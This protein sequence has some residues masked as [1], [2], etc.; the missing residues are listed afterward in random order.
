MRILHV[1]DHSVPAAQRLYLPHP[2]HPARAAAPGL[3]DPAP[4]HAQAGPATKW[5]EERVDGL[6]L[7]PHAQRAGRRAAQAQMRLTAARIAEL[8]DAA[9]SPTWCTRTRRCSM[10][11]RRCGCGCR[12]VCRWSTKMRA[13]WEDAA[14]DHGTTTEGSLRYRLSR[15][16]ESFALRR[17]DQVT[18]ICEGLRGDIVGARHSG[19]PHHRDSERGGRAVNF[20][21]GVPADPALQQRLGL[22]G[23]TVLG[24]M[25]ARSTAT[26][27]CTLLMEAVL[28]LHAASWPH[29]APAAGGRRPTGGVALKA[30]VAQRWAC[31]DTVVFTGRVPHATRCS[32][33]TN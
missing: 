7:P 24:F 27:A 18:T 3:A 12:A 26:R 19:R 22:Q 5:R 15:G 30:Q 23:C 17:A 16:L 9:S 20:Q 8:V 28:A 11:C 6:E 1:L 32:A 4:H 31:T 10:R 2:G 33:T 14:V 13:S 25:P 29:V 21:F